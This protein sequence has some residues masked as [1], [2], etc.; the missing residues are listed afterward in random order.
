MKHYDVGPLMAD[1][2]VWLMVYSG[3]AAG[4]C[5]IYLC[6]FIA[7]FFVTILYEYNIAALE[8][9]QKQMLDEWGQQIKQPTLV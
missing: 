4:W 8:A 5:L 1:P 3:A 9:H 7:R 6:R 2:M